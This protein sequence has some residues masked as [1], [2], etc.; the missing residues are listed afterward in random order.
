MLHLENL[1]ELLAGKPMKLWGLPLS[2]RA[3]GVLT[4]KLIHTQPPAV[5][6]IYHLS[7]FIS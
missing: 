1:V 4:L 2:Y 5:S 7:V 6:P 3:P